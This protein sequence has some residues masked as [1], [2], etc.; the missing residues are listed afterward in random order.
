MTELPLA[1]QL[2]L[3]SAEHWLENWK[4]IEDARIT[5]EYCPL[6][7]EYLT[8]SGCGACPIADFTLASGCD[9]T[10]W[11][12]ANYYHGSADHIFKHAAEAEYRFLLCLAFGDEDEARVLCE[13]WGYV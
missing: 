9:D 4:D 13:E 1:T 11:V 6:C 7:E 12:S 3:E 2:L 8:T 10:P 5:G